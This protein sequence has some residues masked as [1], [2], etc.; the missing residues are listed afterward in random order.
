MTNGNR[1][2]GLTNYA[3]MLYDRG[4]HYVLM[5]AACE[6]FSHACANDAVLDNPNRGEVLAQFD[7]H[8]N[9]IWSRYDIPRIVADVD[10]LNHPM[11]RSKKEREYRR[12][13]LNNRLF[14]NPLN[15]VGPYPIAAHDVMTL[16]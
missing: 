7:M 16:P 8:M 4:H 11:G 10:L 12:W 9:A 3:Q 6:S 14:I 13:C 15:D 2:L 1:G 5:A